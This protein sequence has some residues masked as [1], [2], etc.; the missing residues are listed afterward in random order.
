MTEIPNIGVMPA[1]GLGTWR[2]AGRECEHAIKEALDM[3]YWHI[4]TADDSDRRARPHPRRHDAEG[5]RA[6]LGK[7]VKPNAAALKLVRDHYVKTGRGGMEMTPA[8]RKMARLPEGSTPLPNQPGT[9]PG[10][11][12][13]GRRDG[14]LLPPWSAARD[15]EHLRP[16][17][18]SGDTSEDRETVHHEGSHAPTG[19]LRV[20]NL[21][22]TSRRP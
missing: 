10:V 13:R 18:P 4:D 7:K 11:R 16:L 3:G 2:L 6:G 12:M 22:P 15:E 21:H 8:R 17:R 9:A 19:R 5:G 20:D 14:G 1:V